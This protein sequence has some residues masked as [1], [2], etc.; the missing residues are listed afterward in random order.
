[1]PKST[2]ASGP[3]YILRVRDHFEAAHHLYAYR[4]HAEPVH[5]HNWTVEVVIETTK[6]H[7]DGYGFDFMR[8]KR[9]LAKLVKPFHHNHVNSVAP[10]DELTPTTEHLAGFFFEE[11][12]RRLPKAPIT[13][14]TV[15]EGPDCSATYRA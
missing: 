7:A 11:L 13:E 9:A 4:G 14:V 2:N 5:G 3:T 6:L 12:S 10:F 1:M 8:V 15:W